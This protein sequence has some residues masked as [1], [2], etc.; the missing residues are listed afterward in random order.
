MGILSTPEPQEQ[1]A[2]NVKRKSKQF[3][4]GSLGPLQ[5]KGTVGFTGYREAAARKPSKTSKRDDDEM[6]SDADDDT[7]PTK[8][9]IPTIKEGEDGGEM[10]LSPEELKR[11]SDLAEGVKKIQVSSCVSLEY[12]RV[13]RPNSVSSS[14]ANTPS[15]LQPPQ[16]HGNHQSPPAAQHATSTHLHHQ[17]SR[18]PPRQTQ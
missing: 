10:D 18:L 15:T 12:N 9:G 16:H 17:P 6:D 11:Q 7:K 1:K 13:T 8:D 2:S 14:N 4:F 3:D 5:P